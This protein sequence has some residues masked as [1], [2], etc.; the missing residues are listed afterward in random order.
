MFLS[1]VLWESGGLRHKR[2]LACIETGCP[3]KYDSSEGVPG[4]NYYGRG[5]IQ[6][7]HSYNYKPA[8][9]AIY[10]DDRLITNPD[11]VADDEDCSWGMWC[12][13]Q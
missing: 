8:S 13:N 1:Q 6:L 11:L 9:M 4:K 5:Y 10:G 12:F 2:E 7:T 3:G